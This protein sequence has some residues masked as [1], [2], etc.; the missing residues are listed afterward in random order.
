MT[1]ELSSDPLNST[2]AVKVILNSDVQQEKQEVKTKTLRTRVVV[3]KKP[4]PHTPKPYQTKQR[5][6]RTARAK[7]GNILYEHI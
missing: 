6:S 2:Y 7:P 1:N 3:N 5:R 4:I